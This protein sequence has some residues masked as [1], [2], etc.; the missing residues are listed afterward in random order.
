[1]GRAAVLLLALSAAPAAAR[2]IHEAVQSG[3]VKYVKEALAAGADINQIG[4][5]GQSPLMAASLQGHARVAKHLLEQGADP[6]IAEKDGYTPMHGAGFQ[7]RPEV[8]KV[9]LAAGLD[10]SERHKDGFTPLHRACWGREKRHAEMVRVLL[11]A[12]VSAD[13]A[14]DNGKTCRD[15]THNPHT[16]KVL[17]EWQQK[18][19]GGEL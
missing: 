17:D 5:G 4:S 9:L 19:G 1:M 7:G 13:E 10:R 2:S 11:E 16:I 8:A 6:K 3:R 15:M 12:G 14:A 18:G